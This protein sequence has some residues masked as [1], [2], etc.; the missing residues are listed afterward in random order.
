M[1][2]KAISLP[3]YKEVTLILEGKTSFLAALEVP[4]ASMYLQ[5]KFS[6]HDFHF[7]SFQLE[8]ATIHKV[9]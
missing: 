9:E 3:Q 1:H 5:S 4:V 6:V 8:T 7:C 2:I